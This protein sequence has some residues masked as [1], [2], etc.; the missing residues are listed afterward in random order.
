MADTFE[1]VVFNPNDKEQ[2]DLICAI[3]SDVLPDSFVVE[4]GNIFMKKFYYKCLPEIGSLKCFLARYNGKYVGMIVTNKKPF[5]LIRS[6]IPIY[7]WRISLVM[8]ASML[9][10]PKRIATIIKLLKYKP[11]PLLKQMEDSK[12]AFEILTIGVLNDYRKIYITEKEKISHLILKHAVSDYKN[13]GYK[14]ITGQILKSNRMAL[15]F[16]ETFNANF[17]QSTTNEGGVILDLNIDNVK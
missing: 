2:M 1:I 3:H 5:S 7:F 10:G 6:A 16:Y 15:G 9:T 4:M 11:D 8:S 13:N 17:I 12:T 14:R